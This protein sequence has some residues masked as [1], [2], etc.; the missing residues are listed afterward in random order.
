[1]TARRFA[2]AAGLAGLLFFA[3]TVAVAQ[4]SGAVGRGKVKYEH[5]CAPCHGRG[6]GDDGR[7]MLP[8]TAALRIKYRGSVPAVLEDRAGL[9]TEVLRTFVRQGSWSMPPFRPTELTDAEIEDIA[10][11]LAESSSRAG[12]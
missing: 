6:I 12:G 7:E 9:T 11:Y 10:A 1:M 4:D 3:G 8:G 2:R 5:T